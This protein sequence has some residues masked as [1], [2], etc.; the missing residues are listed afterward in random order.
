M[1]NKRREMETKLSGHKRDKKK[2]TPPFLQ[3]ENISKSSWIDD[4]LPEM[5]WAVLAIVNFEREKALDF[6]RHVAK[7]VKDNPDCYDVTLM[8]ISRFP[9]KK[10]KE[11]ILHLVSWS[12]DIKDTLRP[13]LLFPELPAITDWKGELNNPIEKEDWQ[14]LSEGVAKTFWH[15]SQEATDCR[16][17]KLFSQ[18]FGGKMKF[19]QEMKDTLRGIFEYPNYGDMRKIR[20]SIRAMEIAPN[21][22]EK[23]LKGTWAKAFWEYCFDKTGCTPE[24]D[25]N[26]KIK[27]R[28]QEL[29]DECKQVRKH[30]FDETVELRNK[31]IDHALKTAKTSSVD[32]R[33]EGAFGLALYALTLFIEIIFYRAQ[34]SI[35]GRLA[36]RTLAETQITFAYLLK[37]EKDEPR[38]WE[39]YRGYG[40]GQT[41]L[42][43]LKLQELDEKPSSISL[44]EL[45][46][47]ANEDAWIEFIPINLG[48]WDE[49][50]LRKMSEQVGLKSLYDKLYNYTSGYMHANW[51]S[52]RES[53]YQRCMNPLHRYHRIPTFD[54]PLLPSVTQDAEEIT[55]NILDYLSQAYPEFKYRIKALDERKNNKEKK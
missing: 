43:Y 50:D 28:Q 18:I 53:I 40:T 45:D 32:P 22:N 7:F 14:E 12:Q 19:S 15:Q 13:M 10:R 37:K 23:D 49:V 34:L 27:K 26:K 44:D 16:W 29:A 41:K 31:L 36:L 3:I 8:G 21:T 30:Y 38:V 6:F 20:L 4:R 17:I 35:T 54:L 11:F 52:V 25:V 42:I 39:D 51:G 9:K 5:L 2:L 47:I 55:N 1:N 33:H 24:H 48:H 46:Y